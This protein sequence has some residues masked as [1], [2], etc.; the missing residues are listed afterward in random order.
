[1][2][3]FK[4]LHFIF[5]IIFPLEQGCGSLYEQTRIIFNQEC[6]FVKLVDIGPVVL[7][8]LKMLSCIFTILQLSPL[9]KE[10]SLSSEQIGFP[11]SH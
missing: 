3:F 2:K 4:Y 9:E 7:E 6:F 5:V 10:P 1:M 8:D 11:F